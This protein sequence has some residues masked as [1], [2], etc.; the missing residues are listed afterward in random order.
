MEKGSHQ[1]T[2]EESRQIKQLENS[3]MSRHVLK[4]KQ[5]KNSIKLK[6]NIASG[7]CYSY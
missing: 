2:H 4:R 7:I 1:R 6:E 5:K 3:L